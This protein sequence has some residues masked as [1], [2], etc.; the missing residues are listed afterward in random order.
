MKK[1]IFV[2]FS[3]SHMTI[4]LSV[5]TNIVSATVTRV[6]REILDYQ[7][8]ESKLFEEH[9]AGFMFKPSYYLSALRFASFASLETWFSNR[10]QKITR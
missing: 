9:N 6:W 8:K 10:A 7:T 3:K 5:H 4:L 2:C 1:Y